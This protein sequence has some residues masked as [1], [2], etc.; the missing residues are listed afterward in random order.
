MKPLLIT[1]AAMLAFAS[2]PSRADDAV[3]RFDVTP[4][5]GIYV[6]TGDQ[7]DLLDHAIWK[8]LTASYDLHRFA[9]VTGSFAWT[10][11]ETKAVFGDDELDLFQYDVGVESHY[12]FLVAG[13][14]TLQPFLA[15]GGGARTYDFRDRDVGAETDLVGYVAAGVTAAHGRFALELGARDNLTSFDG[16]SGEGRDE[17]WNDL[18]VFA[19][20]GMRF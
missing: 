17:T 15:V 5:V 16:L 4:F 18:N 7:R 6:P 8:G 19:G 20:V 13:G 10:S 3:R 2:T 11:T 14:L 12:P 9:S 1:I